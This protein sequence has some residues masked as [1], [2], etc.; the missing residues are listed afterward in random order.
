MEFV[1]LIPGLP[2]LGFLILSLFNKYIPKS[3]SGYIAS[4]M[5]LGS[6]LVVLSLLIPAVSGTLVAK[7]PFVLFNWIQAGNLN[8]SLS[9]QIDNLS[10]WFM[11]IITGVGFLIHMYSISY[12]HDDEGVTRYFSYLNLFIFSM[13]LLV[14]GSNFAVMF[15]GWEGVGLCSYFGLKIKTIT[16]LQRKLLS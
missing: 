2:L 9:F 13:L 3:A 10:I 16:M 7:E 12:M 4:A 6:F 14:M 8:L 15:M 1:W 5:L 11:S